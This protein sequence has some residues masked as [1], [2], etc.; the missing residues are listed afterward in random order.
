MDVLFTYRMP[1][2]LLYRLARY[3]KLA[4]LI[5]KVYFQFC[6]I[7]VILSLLSEIDRAMLC[8]VMLTPYKK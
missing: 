6:H 5:V 4:F 3:A 1:H 2:Q 8:Y 7:C